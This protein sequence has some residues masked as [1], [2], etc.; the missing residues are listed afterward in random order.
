[1]HETPPRP[2]H[3]PYVIAQ[4]K[5]GKDAH[6]PFPPDESPPVSKDKTKI[7]Q[8]VVGT[9]LLYARSVDSTFLFSLNSI[10]IQ[11]TSVTNNTLKRTEDFL[12]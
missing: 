7:I 8:C 2:Q 9:I 11:Q 4:K 6:D 12:S 3:L 10:E 5:Y 1:M